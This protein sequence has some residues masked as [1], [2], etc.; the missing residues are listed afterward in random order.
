MQNQQVPI[1]LPR[2][3]HQAD[4]EERLSER[5]TE[6]NE[7]LTAPARS[8]RPPP[9]AAIATG[10]HPGHAGE[11]VGRKTS[12]ELRTPQLPHE[13]RGKPG[14][15][16]SS[17]FKND[18]SYDESSLGT[19]DPA[20]FE[21]QDS[22]LCEFQV[23]SPTRPQ[24]PGYHPKGHRIRQTNQLQDDNGPM[25]GQGL[26]PGPQE[27]ADSSTAGPSQSREAPPH[28][29]AL[30]K[31]R[32]GQ[33]VPRRAPREV[34]SALEALSGLP[35]HIVYVGQGKE[36]PPRVLEE[37]SDRHDSS[38]HLY[39]FPAQAD[40]VLLLCYV[41]CLEAAMHLI[42]GFKKLSYSPAVLPL[43][44]RPDGTTF[45][46]KQIN[47]SS[48]KLTK[49][50]ADD[51]M[52]QPRN[53]L[54]LP[55]M[56]QTSLALVDV[57][58]E[59]E[60]HLLEQIDDRA[61]TL[62]FQTVD[63]IIQGFPKLNSSVD[64]IAPSRSDLGG[65][66]RHV[67]VNV[68]GAGKFGKVYKTRVAAQGSP[69]DVA[70]EAVKVI[71]KCSIRTPKHANQVMKECRLLQRVSGH[72]NVAEF[73]GLVH[74]RRSLY[75]FMEFVGAMDLVAVIRSTESG[76]LESAHVLELLLQ[77][78]DAVAYCHK[79]LVAHRD[80]K[81]E[82]I[83]V[84]GE[85]IPKLVDFGLAVTLSNANPQELCADKCGT[86]PFAPPEVYRGKKFD[87]QAMDVWSLG[88]LTLEMR[89]GNNS[90]CRM[91]GCV[92]MGEPNADL[93]DVFDRFFSVPD[94]T[95]LVKNVHGIGMA[96]ELLTILRYSL[97]V[98]PE[99]RWHA[100]DLWHHIA[101]SRCTDRHTRGMT[102]GGTDQ[103]HQF[104]RLDLGA[105][106]TGGSA[107]DNNL[108]MEYGEQVLGICAEI[109]FDNDVVQTRRLSSEFRRMQH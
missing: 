87:A 98:R 42:K 44:L 47:T 92:G 45:D 29:T 19:C 55:D 7:R 50:G 8:A 80:I 35:L 3:N 39:D 30:H 106:E 24:P 52:V 63:K 23:S 14:P 68:I 41:T 89:C 101:D 46:N 2:I 54:D 66:G 105:R 61:N 58:M 32:M 13:P 4:Y 108:D 104:Q 22:V 107:N 48:A 75:I 17:A 67:F 11:E 6:N 95:T 20:D 90:V 57:H 25:Y 96:P 86:I 37:P 81:S 91:V 21:Q 62:F 100:I 94:W 43:L 1:S 31:A 10:R 74:A 16:R 103:S 34:Q 5:L 79:S 49:S 102:R 109:P 77:I 76:R 93:A 71:P 65:V 40:A 72:P 27:Y 85:G 18:E 64:E 73:R 15:R 88:I 51:V 84:T 9:L 33:A 28:T 59:V 38:K 99:Q 36:D 70:F 83:V 82:N 60:K 78:I 26:P 12:V 56:L 53:K 97:V 69:S